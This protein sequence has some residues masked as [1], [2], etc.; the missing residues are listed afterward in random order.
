M[1]NGRVDM[2]YGI[3]NHNEKLLK[4]ESLESGFDSLQIRIWYEYSLVYDRDLIIIKRTDGIWSAKH[5]EMELN[6]DSTDNPTTFK[7]VK[8]KDVSPESGWP[9]FINKILE[10]GITTLPNMDAIPGLDDSW[11][12][13]V[14]FNIEIATKNQYR[15]YGYH[16]PYQ[17][18]DKFWQAKKMTEILNLLSNELKK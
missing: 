4:L 6:P 16:V 17:F 9:D 11:L 13:G 15:F 1:F 7:T 5:Y 10:L 14:T 8:V 18:A 2:W 3:K 12:D